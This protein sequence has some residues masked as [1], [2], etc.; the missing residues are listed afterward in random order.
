MREYNFAFGRIKKGLDEQ[1]TG[2]TKC[3]ILL[4]YGYNS[5]EDEI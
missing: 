4:K 3:Y 5:K 1:V 2:I